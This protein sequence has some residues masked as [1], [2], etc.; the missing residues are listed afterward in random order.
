MRCLN[1]RN[2][3]MPLREN[4]YF[5]KGVSSAKPAHCVL[6]SVKKDLFSQHF[7]KVNLQ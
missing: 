4:N 3:N 6:M 7:Q 2:E 1:A 5:S